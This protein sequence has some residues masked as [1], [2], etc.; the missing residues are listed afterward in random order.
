MLNSDELYD[1]ENIKITVTIIR[2]VIVPFLAE[3]LINPICLQLESSDAANPI[4]SI[5]IALINSVIRSSDSQSIQQV[6]YLIQQ[7]L[8]NFIQSS[9]RLSDHTG[10][11]LLSIFFDNIRII[12]QYP[13][14][15]EYEEWSRVQRTLIVCFLFVA[16]LSRA[17][18]LGSCQFERTVQM[19][20]AGSKLFGVSLLNQQVQVC[21]GNVEQI[22]L[23]V[24]N[25]TVLRGRKLGVISELQNVSIM[26]YEHGVKAL[27]DCLF[28][29]QVYCVTED[30][31]L[32]QE[33]HDDD[34][35]PGQGGAAEG[36]KDGAVTQERYQAMD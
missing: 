23:S 33:M 20:E 29:S 35:R 2:F 28:A 6:V 22:S 16:R 32:G 25:Q 24:C 12:Q 14:D 10:G 30:D 5:A 3:V 4:L 9:S 7:L 1:A 21:S 15:M 8:L 17:L 11:Q 26:E 34:I 13:A 27:L 31:G 19:F 18:E 36:G